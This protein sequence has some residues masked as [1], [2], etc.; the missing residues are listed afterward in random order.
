MCALGNQKG[1]V[2]RPTTIF[3]LARSGMLCGLHVLVLDNAP[4]SNL[5]AVAAA[6]PVTEKQRRPCP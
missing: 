5:T 3:H 1:G 6:E 4:P 2:G